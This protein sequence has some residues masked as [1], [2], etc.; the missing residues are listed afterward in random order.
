MDGLG[1]HNYKQ[2]GRKWIPL[3]CILGVEWVTIIGVLNFN[4]MIH[5]LIHKKRL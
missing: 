2:K 4:S 5:I 1:A 3:C